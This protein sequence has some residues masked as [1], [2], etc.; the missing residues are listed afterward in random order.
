MSPSRKKR[1]D[2][3]RQEP[4]ELLALEASRPA[5]KK[6]KA[7]AGK[8]K[9]KAGAR[10]GGGG[11]SSRWLLKTFLVMATGVVLG[12][13]I[14]VGALVREAQVTVASRLEG[15]V[16]SEPARVW[17]APVEVWKGLRLQPSELAEDLRAAGYTQV[18]Q[19]KEA[20]DFQVASDAVVIR[21]APAEGPGWTI[22]KAE[23]LV[24]FKGSTVASVT[25]RSPVRLAPTVLATLTGPSAER[26]QM[27]PLKEIPVLLQK[28]VLAMEDSRFY[29][30]KG[31]SLLGVL[32]ALVV[33]V[34][35][36]Q[37]VQGG[38][39]LTQQLAKN[40]FLSPDRT[41]ARKAREAFL[42]LAI[43]EKLSKDEILE[44]YLNGVYFGQ[45]GGQAVHG[46]A[47]AA[48]VFFGKPLDRLSLGECALLS[49]I[50]SAPNEYSPLR[51][52]DRATERRDVALDRLVE[53]G[54]IDRDQATRARQEPLEIR[55]TAIRRA[56]YWG[57]DFGVQAAEEREGEGTLVSRSLA[58][59]TTLS[60][61]LQRLA[62]WA[63]AEGVAEVEA[64][65][66]GARGVEAALVVLDAETGEIRA[67][68]GGRDYARSS[69][70]RAAHA[71][72]QLGSLVKPLI[73][74][75]ALDA[76]PTLTLATALEDKPFERTTGGKVWRPQNYDGR[77]LGEVTV[78]DAIVH[79]RN[80]P[81][82]H[83]AEKVGLKRLQSFWVQAGLTR[84]GRMPSAALGAFDA[85]PLE[86]AQAYT[87]FPG[88]GTTRS[89]YA[90]RALADARG[91]VLWRGASERQT[92]ASA[93][94]A[95]LARRVLED[96]MRDGT[97]A[98]ARGYGVGEAAAGK[99]GTTDAG[100]DAWFAGFSPDLLAVVWVGFD[101]QKVHGLTGAQ[102]ALP[103]WSRFMAGSG[104]TGGTWSGSDD[105]VAVPLCAES[106]L[107]AVTD[108]ATVKT[109][110]F[111]P[112]KV[113][114][115]SCTLH[116]GK[117][118]VSVQEE[119]PKE[120]AQKPPE[121]RDTLIQRIRKSLERR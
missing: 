115:G 31:V 118:R 84:A 50:I 1:P 102:A 87:L 55:P 77:F 89:P 2:V 82:I 94:R 99:T 44:L 80:I 120:E 37:T 92:L 63:L 113:P 104:T 66:P 35:A 97:G 106:G 29:D 57:V 42:A 17:S 112:G 36:G 43:E 108:C 116:S 103:I 52:P 54:A 81:T 64:R 95:A 18:D 107:P 12:S 68:V 85:T 30:H 41:V 100:R 16:W 8:K 48:R 93:Q 72:R 20:G 114:A 74:V 70:N 62:E 98:G 24:S 91:T 61:P 7:G 15:Q 88:R 6:G 28:A 79:S 19:V 32:R 39:T 13:A 101:E 121:T 47:E 45:A 49:G 90:V 10:K 40:L 5:R 22:G 25:P 53:T 59:W 78:R 14:V 21:T 71:W 3:E 46:V 105:L 73:L 26:R 4:H 83:L 33:N 60:P 11:G 75:E 23:V 86:V 117:P 56:T 110:W 119:K 34:T 76:D 38:S 111:A 69:F 96:V 109:L 65:H 58:V 9:G 51:N 67:M 27:V